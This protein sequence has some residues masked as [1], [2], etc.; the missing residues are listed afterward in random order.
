MVPMLVDADNR[1]SAA[2]DQITQ[3]LSVF[4]GPALAGILIAGT[5]RLSGEGVAFTIDAASFAVSTATLFLIRGGCVVTVCHRRERRAVRR[6]RGRGCAP[7]S[8]RASAMPGVIPSSA[9]LIIIAGT[10]V[11]ANA[12][13]GVGLPVLA[14]SHFAGGAAAFGAGALVGIA[15]AG[16]IA[17]PHR[18]RLVMVGV[19]M[20]FATATLLLPF[21]PNLPS[22]LVVL[23][24][25]ATGTGAVNV[26]LVPWLQNRTDPAMFGRVN[27]IM[28]V[29]SIGLTPV[30]YAAAGWVASVN[31]D[32]LFISGAI[33]I[34]ATALFAL[35]SRQIRCVD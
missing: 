18:W 6:G 12:I 27:S 28:Q 8:S 7:R 1:A 19:T 29:A 9:L 24:L 22:A 23:L 35:A 31:L 15:I 26:F 10:D 4:I 11:T 5:G 2:L 14:R 34:F 16:S 25:V 21:L 17:R 20:S 30:T 33:L 13:I 3:R 32:M